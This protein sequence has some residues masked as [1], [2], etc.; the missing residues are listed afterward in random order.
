[1]DLMQNGVGGDE[2]RE[3]FMVHIRK[4]CPERVVAQSLR[5][6]K[7]IPFRELLVNRR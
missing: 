3:I 7:A 1:M 4:S 5:N 6:D 2:Y